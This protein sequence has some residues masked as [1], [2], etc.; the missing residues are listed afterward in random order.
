MGKKQRAREEKAEKRERRGA[1]KAQKD[2]NVKIGFAVGA[3]VI[4]VYAHL[5]SASP[6]RPPAALTAAAGMSWRC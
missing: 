6:A 5:S 2:R 3:G 4:V 1:E